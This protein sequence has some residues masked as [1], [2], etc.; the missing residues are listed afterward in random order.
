MENHEAF[1]RFAGKIF[2]RE[3]ER[4]TGVQLRVKGIGG[5]FGKQFPDVWLERIV[6]K[7]EIGVEFAIITLGFISEEQTYFERTYRKQFYHLLE[8]YRPHYKNVG[9]TLQPSMHCIQALRSFKLPKVASSGGKRLIAEFKTFLSQHHLPPTSQGIL[10]EKLAFPEL[11]KYFE[12]VLLNPIRDD[13]PRKPHPDDPII[14][15]SVIYDG[16]AIERVT[17]ETFKGKLDKGREYTADILVLHTLRLSPLR[18]DGIPDLSMP[19]VSGDMIGKVMGIPML[20]L[21]CL[22]ERFK[23]IWFL[24]AYMTAEG[25]RLYRLTT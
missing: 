17:Q 7:W 12:A 22:Q 8:A 20:E 14:T 16:R 1:N 18:A 5:D 3:Y 24:D 23:E 19:I 15:L 21:K 13:D 25:K 2:A 9:I 4:E 6:D 11:T 10:L